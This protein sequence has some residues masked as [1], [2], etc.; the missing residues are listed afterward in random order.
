MKKLYKSS[1]DKKICG[2]CGGIA[3][4]F[5]IDSTVIRLIF[6]IFGLV[7]VGVVFYILAA[8]LMPQDDAAY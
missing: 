6:V 1:R 4:Y 3:E 5:N 8:L 2:V 7:S